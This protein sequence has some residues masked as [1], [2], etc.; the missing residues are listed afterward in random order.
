MAW[1]DDGNGNATG[2]ALYDTD[3]GDAAVHGTA[4]WAQTPQTLTWTLP[5]NS[6][7]TE[8]DL[9]GTFICTDADGIRV[10]P[11]PRAGQA[12]YIRI[13]VVQVGT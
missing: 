11:E 13:K 4:V 12:H 3:L 8:R 10:F 9:L 7:G 5:T 2:A 6:L 1:L